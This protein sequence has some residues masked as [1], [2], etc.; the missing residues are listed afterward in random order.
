MLIE[1]NFFFIYKAVGTQGN[2]IPMFYKLGGGGA[3]GMGS[4][5]QST[6]I[7]HL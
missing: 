2:F 7:S 5:C 1:G 6:G 4:N 3:G